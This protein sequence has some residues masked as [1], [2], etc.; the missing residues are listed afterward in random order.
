[1]KYKYL[2]FDMGNTIIK[3]IKFDTKKALEKLYD[4]ID[5]CLINKDNFIKEGIETLNEIFKK[6]DEDDI[7]IPYQIYIKNILDKYNISNY[8][9]EKIELEMYK[10]SVIDEEIFDIKNFLEELKNKNHELYIL[11]NATFSSNCLKYT[12]EK[13]DVLKYFNNVYSSGDVIHR[14][15]SKLFLEETNILNYIDLNDSIYIGDNE[16][17]DKEFA[18]NL[19]IPF[20]L[21]KDGKPIFDENN[22][23]IKEI[24]NW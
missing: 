20:L 6:R 9:L 19:N 16:Y 2:L 4:I 8:D 18:K 1:M 22:K 12:L 5:N 24:L 7:E 11:S 15:P 23:E 14:K 10:Y 13:F 21:F 17:F 3:N